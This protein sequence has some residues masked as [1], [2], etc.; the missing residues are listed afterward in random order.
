MPCG[1]YI[2]VSDPTMRQNPHTPNAPA[3]RWLGFHDPLTRC[4]PIS[5]ERR[6]GLRPPP[7]SA[8]RPDLRRLLEAWPTLPDPIRAGIVAMVEAAKSAK[9]AKD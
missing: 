2:A 7:P 9:I 5:P 1:A 8:E 4:D 6:G 3:F